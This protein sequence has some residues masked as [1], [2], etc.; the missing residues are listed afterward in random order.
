[1]ILKPL[2]ASHIAY[3]AGPAGTILCANHGPNSKQRSKL[4]G[5]QADNDKITIA[6]F[7]Y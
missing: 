7:L 1:M 6:W 2:L 4:K 5:C 3:V